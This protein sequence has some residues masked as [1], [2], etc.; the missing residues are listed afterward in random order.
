MQSYVDIH[1]HLHAHAV[2]SRRVHKP[3][4]VL[5]VRA[6]WDTQEGVFPQIV[7]ELETTVYG[8]VILQGYYTASTSFF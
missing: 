8:E 6:M 4:F 1:V 7:G 3:V 5:I 2:I